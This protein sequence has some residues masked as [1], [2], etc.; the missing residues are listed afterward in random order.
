[1][2]KD[3]YQI[4]EI[5]SSSNQEEIKA[6]YETKLKENLGESNIDHSKITEAFET[7][8]NQAKR[9]KYDNELLE[10][11]SKE[12]DKRLLE[13][14]K[15][16]KFNLKRDYLNR[17]NFNVAIWIEMF[18]ILFFTYLIYFYKSCVE[19]DIRS[20]VYEAARVAERITLDCNTKTFN[21]FEI[22][23]DSVDSGMS[24]SKN[25]L[26]LVLKDISSN[27]DVC[28]KCL[29][30][31]DTIKIEHK[32]YNCLSVLNDLIKDENL[33]NI[34][35][36]ISNTKNEFQNLNRL[37]SAYRSLSELLNNQKIGLNELNQKLEELRNE[38]VQIGCQ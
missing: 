13:I 30:E 4:L 20:E 28:S 24:M 9:E 16:T 6:A 3:Y 22:Y 15:K 12:N 5:S 31:I 27:L 11:L 21:E 26:L 2:L 34:M 18:A 19:N 33:N 32:R 1:M 29:S 10:S 14:R 17:K 23:I 7:L 35:S 38:F 25:Q 37:S 36:K 8:S